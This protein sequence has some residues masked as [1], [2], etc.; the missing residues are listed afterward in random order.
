MRLAAAEPAWAEL[1]GLSR[2]IS[3]VASFTRRRTPGIALCEEFIR[4]AELP[5]GAA[6][7]AGVVFCWAGSP[8]AASTG[9]AVTSER[10]S[11]ET[12][13]S[14]PARRRFLADHAGPMKK[15]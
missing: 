5:E 9:L 13:G 2:A 7:G 1:C 4:S 8:V 6:A 11:R 3:A 10:T 15:P 12:T 14:K